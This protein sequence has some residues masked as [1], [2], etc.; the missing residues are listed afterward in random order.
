MSDD[1][2]EI[3]TVSSHECDEFLRLMCSA[4]V[5]EFDAARPIFYADP[6]FEPSNKFVAR[7]NGQIVS[8]LTVVDRECWIGETVVHVAGIAGVCTRP[9]LRRR[10]LAGRLITE[11]ARVLADRGYAVAALFPTDRQYYRKLGWETVGVELRARIPANDLSGA[12]RPGGVRQVAAEDIPQIAR[13][14][15]R[16]AFGRTM[17]CL[18]DD[19]RWTF[20]LE[21]LPE[22]LV[23]YTDSGAIQGYVLQ[24]SVPNRGA[25]RYST[26]ALPQEP[27][28]RVLE[29]VCDTVDAGNT[30]RGYLRDQ[31]RNQ[32]FEFT[33][34][35]DVLA[36]NGFSVPS[37]PEPGIMARILNWPRLLEELALQW[38]RIDGE[39]GIALVDPFV[40]V[41]PLTAV[42]RGAGDCSAIEHVPPALMKERCPNM[43]VGDLQEWSRV[44]IGHVS[45]RTACKA[46]GLKSSTPLALEFADR[47][48]PARNPFMPIADHF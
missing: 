43:I 16:A 40:S 36:R 12:A 41:P 46:G 19:K 47:L 30:I 13:I 45:A 7:I 34:T 33:S 11:T 20:I 31:F 23:T 37:R 3:G 21:Y 48:F 38:Q 9:E 22:S 14:Y 39:L 15:D 6:Y 28:R 4:F 26:D 35:E 27:A 24:D 17:H 32:G 5:M 2:V 29:I 44:A 42:I 8:C 25:G 1:L 10:G 18:R